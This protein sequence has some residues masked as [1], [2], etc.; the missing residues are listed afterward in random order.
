V[1]ITDP[2]SLALLSV[3]SDFSLVSGGAGLLV[4]ILRRPADKMARRESF[5]AR[6]ASGAPE[7]PDGLSVFEIVAFMATGEGLRDPGL[8]RVAIFAFI[9]TGEGLR[10][11]ALWRA[12]SN[13]SVR[14]FFFVLFTVVAFI[15][16]GDDLR[17]PKFWLSVS[18]KSS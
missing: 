2:S 11:P 14:D 10:D 16:T 3:S 1:L 9:M 8:C 7:G 15:V 13:N 6:F 12:A 17:D 4:F 18:V 5:L